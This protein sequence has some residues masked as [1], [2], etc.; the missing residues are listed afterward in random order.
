MHY[1]FVQARVIRLNHESHSLAAQD[2]SANMT[3]SAV[4]PFVQSPGL[5]TLYIKFYRTNDGQNNSAQVQSPS[6]WHL[7]AWMMSLLELMIVIDLCSLAAGN[8]FVY[9]LQNA[10]AL[11]QA[12][13][14]INVANIGGITSVALYQVHALQPANPPNSCSIQP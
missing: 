8:S 3:G 4:I 2:Y 14:V 5:A 12:D 10:V 11:V 13:Y 6:R 9:Q 7:Q 1:E